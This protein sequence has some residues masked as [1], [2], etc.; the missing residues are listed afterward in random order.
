MPPDFPKALIMG[1]TSKLVEMISRA[2][3]WKEISGRGGWL[4]SPH[5]NRHMFPSVQYNSFTDLL[6]LPSTLFI[7]NHTP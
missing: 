7:H 3:N 2:L 5:V 1:L 4:D 6:S